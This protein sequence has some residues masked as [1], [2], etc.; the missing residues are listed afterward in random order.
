MKWG[1]ELA[2][3][4]RAF[5]KLSG[6]AAIGPCL[7]PLADAAPRVAPQADPTHVL[8]IRRAAVELAPGHLVTTL[9]YDGRLPGPLLRSTVGQPMRVDVYNETDA[10][11]RVH[12]HGQD[13]APETAT[14]VPARSR[15]RL[16]FTPTRP[17]LFFYHS[18]VV[19]AANLDAGLYSGQVGGLLVEDT[20][21]AGDWDREFV[22]VIKECEPFIRRTRRGCEIGYR[23]VTLNGRLLGHGACARINSGE[24]VLL[25]VL[26]GSATE[27]RSLSLPGHSFV[28][29]ALD[30][31]PAPSPV[32]VAA[33]HL[34]PGERVS[35]IVEAHAGACGETEWV[36]RDP[37]NEYWDY[38]RFG[39]GAPREPGAGR[40]DTGCA[41]AG[42][43]DTSR[44]DMGRA[45]MRR[46]DTDQ[47]D[48]RLEMVLTRHDAARSG[49]NSWSI[50][51]TSYSAIEPRPLFR[52]RGG[53]RHRLRIRNTSDEILPLHL[54][55]HR[56]E[57]V[58]VAGIATAGILKD[59]V[60]VGPHQQLEV[61]FVADHRG[62]ALFYCTRQL[63]RDF[64][65][66]A[67][68][69]S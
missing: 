62:P 56:L 50:N 16:E 47:P 37:G 48:A 34:S 28:V 67:L 33:L 42:R 23:S 43:A 12:W 41:D 40:A 10:A 53:L 7:E 26:N 8:R 25:H 38:S 30:G 45:D 24:R 63:H 54:Q 59:V 17:G 22:V 21:G 19:A 15:R 36:M 39:S 27:P 5:L 66:M 3:G 44:A 35:A 20:T 52:L 6:A 58:R 55:R 31:N 69:D 9:T 11:E 46:A 14:P 2:L 61:D 65:L 13:N 68:I 18:H 51:G 32:K 29:M 4:R 64:G 1:Y 49:F 57:I 60:T